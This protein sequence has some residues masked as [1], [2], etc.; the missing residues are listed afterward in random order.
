MLNQNIP[1]H[2]KI[3]LYSFQESK[4]ISSVKLFDGKV[5]PDSSSFFNRKDIE[6][7]SHID[8]NHMDMARFRSASCQAYKDFAAA[9]KGFLAIIQARGDRIQTAVQKAEHARLVAERQGM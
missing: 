3:K 2:E 5:V 4:G 1:P 8:E 9:L 7:H 6:Q